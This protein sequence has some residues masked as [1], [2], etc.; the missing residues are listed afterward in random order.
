LRG[1]SVAEVH[2]FYCQIR[3]QEVPL[4]R[5][6]TVHQQTEGNPLFVQEVLH[7]KWCS[8]AVRKSL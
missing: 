7:T 5:A 6:E 4:S 8:W 3:A 2:Q 1:L